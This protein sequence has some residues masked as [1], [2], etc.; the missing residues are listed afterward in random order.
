MENEDLILTRLLKVLSIILILF[1]LY[2]RSGAIVA[3]AC[4]YW[5]AAKNPR[6]YRVIINIGI[7][8]HS[9]GFL[10]ELYHLAA[11]K[12]YLSYIS[13]FFN[14]FALLL[15]IKYYP[16]PYPVIM[17][18]LSFFT[19]TEMNVNLLDKHP[20]FFKRPS[21]KSIVGTVEG[22]YYNSDAF[23]IILPEQGFQGFTPGREIVAAARKAGVREGGHLLD[24]ASGLG[25]PSCML[26]GEFKIRVTGIDL[27]RRNATRANALASSLNLADRVKF[28][29]ANALKL[30]FR[31]GSFDYIFG[32]DAWCHV[33]ERKS[34]LKEC[35]RILKDDGII[36]F[37]DWLDLGALS[38]GFRFVYSF[39]PLETLE[40]YR[41]KLRETG[42]DILF[43]EREDESLKKSVSGIRESVKRNKRR[44]IEECGRELY[45]NWDFIIQYT[46][47]MIAEG[48]LGH[49]LFIAKK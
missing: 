9:L 8:L 48:K 36:F 40:S 33:P 26:A 11:D 5:I 32:S 23:N 3:I 2:T 18:V 1:G 31:R 39:P 35:A 4:G 45:D 29:P 24:V 12:V 43:A 22:L 10:Q 34:L 38:E 20:S 37:F 27:L 41:E 46:W 7:I 16:S 47:K 28:L 44:I 49:G 6:R 25:G 19:P 21:R 42:F 14:P 13:L 30:P 17:S 15:L